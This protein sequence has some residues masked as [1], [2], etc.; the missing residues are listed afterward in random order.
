MTDIRIS[1]PFTPTVR[2][3]DINDEMAS[4]VSFD[5][6]QF[7]VNEISQGFAFSWQTYLGSSIPFT[8]TVISHDSQVRKVMQN[9]FG[10]VAT[11]SV[12][13]AYED[14]ASIYLINANFEAA[15]G[16]SGLLSSVDE[17]NTLA[18]NYLAENANE[19]DILA[20]IFLMNNQVD[21]EE[22]LGEIVDACNVLMIKA[23]TKT[24]NNALYNQLVTINQA[25]YAFYFALEKSSNHTDP[26]ITS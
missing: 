24:R 11:E 1:I 7:P 21:S 25:A 23:A 14:L 10:D 8:P 3:Q 19:R 20:D 16:I 15:I 17:R 5:F 4:S 6:N 26:N 12:S 2:A 13:V 18:L 9:L 22:K